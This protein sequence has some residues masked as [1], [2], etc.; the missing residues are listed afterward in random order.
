MKKQ[1][2][3]PLA[4]VVAM[5][6]FASCGGGTGAKDVTLK[7]QEDSLNYALG[8]I[9][10]EGIKASYFRTDSTAKNLP[11]LID[12]ADNAFKNTNKDELY[13]YGKQVGGMLKQQKKSG[14]MFDST[15]VFN[16][17]LIKQGL[18]NGMKGFSEGMTGE[19]AQMYIQ[20]TMQKRQERNMPPALPEESV[21]P[22]D[23]VK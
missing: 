5:L 7:T 21:A 13:N 1:N 6:G 22:A 3:L 2:F 14:L 20:T 4:I 11:A 16:E 12:A 9:N 19:Q 15:L 8:I 17:A 10:G 23:T 18:I